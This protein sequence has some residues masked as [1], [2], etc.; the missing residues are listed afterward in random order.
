MSKVSDQ[1]I[2]TFNENFEK[3]V[4]NI[5]NN[6]LA[7]D[8]TCLRNLV[9]LNQNTTRVF[10]E[11][12][13]SMAQNQPAYVMTAYTV[14]LV[15]GKVFGDNSLEKMVLERAKALNAT[16]HILNIKISY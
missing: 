11:V 14:A 2:V 1:E 8:T 4:E 6:Q 5:G 7:I 10:V 13:C 12:Y 9:S 15:Y 16:E 3:C